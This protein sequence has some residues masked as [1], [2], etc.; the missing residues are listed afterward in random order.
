MILTPIQ[1][2][3]RTTTRKCTQ[4]K[5]FSRIRWLIFDR[6]S[7]SIASSIYAGHVENGRR[8][9][10]KREGEYWG[11]SDEK[12]WESMHA[13]H[14]L[15]MILDYQQKNNLFRSPVP[16]TAQN[17]LDVGTGGGVW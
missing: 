15:C 4:L 17:I 7:T 16:E 9:Q 1:H 5:A 3:V 12:Q 6:E 10:T 8:Y 11:P 13:A 14:V 2:L